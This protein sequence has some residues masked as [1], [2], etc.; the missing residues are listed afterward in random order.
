MNTKAYKRARREAFAAERRAILRAKEEAG[1][2]VLGDA[3]ATHGLIASKRHTLLTADAAVAERDYLLRLQNAVPQ[4]TAMSIDKVVQQLWSNDGRY[5]DFDLEQLPCTPPFAELWMEY[6]VPLSVRLEISAGG[7]RGPY[8]EGALFW[9][10]KLADGWRVMMHLF[11]YYPLYE[12][13]PV[14]VA[15]RTML[16]NDLG[17]VRR[18][19]VYG[20]RPVH[21]K[22]AVVADTAV[23]N[24]QNG[25]LVACAFANCKN[26]VQRE[27]KQGPPP[28]TRVKRPGT[29]WRETYRI[30]E[31]SPPPVDKRSP[32]QRARDSKRSVNA[33]HLCRGHFVRYDA[34]APLFGKHV[35]TFWKDP[36]WRGSLNVGIALHDYSVHGEKPEGAA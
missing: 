36:H 1:P 22:L 23:D 28:D 30:L 12:I 29:P 10:E 11:A 15:R 16:L 5:G 2:F 21:G 20:Q 18:D 31:I 8:A 24:M 25:F 32:E 33:L 19:S 34:S 27:V 6:E 13:A 14:F 26:V 17:S 7:H 9:T 4:A 3:I 35:G